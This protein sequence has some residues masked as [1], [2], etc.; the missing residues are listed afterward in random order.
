MPSE[1]WSRGQDVVHF[2]YNPT[3][4]EQEPTGIV[5]V[6]VELFREMLTEMGFHKKP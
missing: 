6:S 5:E 4:N 1:R 2:Y 3:K